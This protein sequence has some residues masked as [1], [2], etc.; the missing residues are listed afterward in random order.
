VIRR[1]Q[2]DGSLGSEAR[3]VAFGPMH[4]E[5]TPCVRDLMATIQADPDLPQRISTLV[6]QSYKAKHGKP[7]QVFKED[8]DGGCP[9]Q[10]GE[11]GAESG[12]DE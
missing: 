10:L 8:D 9:L 4:P 1:I 2:F 7:L 6:L 12:A 11:S 3:S 5:A